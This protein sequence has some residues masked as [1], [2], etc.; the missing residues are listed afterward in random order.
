[1]GQFLDS[2]YSYQF[3]YCSVNNS[4]LFFLTIALLSGSLSSTAHAA[5]RYMEDCDVVVSAS[6]NDQTVFQNLDTLEDNDPT[7]PNWASSVRL[8][9]S[10][11]RD[12]AFF[13]KLLRL[14]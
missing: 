9:P 4:G 11:R 14:P 5:T 2:W 6:E 7:F 13:L 10:Y 8:S 3:R 12:E 1:M